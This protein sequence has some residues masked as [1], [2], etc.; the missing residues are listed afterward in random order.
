MKTVRSTKKVRMVLTQGDCNK[1]TYLELTKIIA[2]VGCLKEG[3]RTT[4]G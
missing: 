2:R 3:K 4:F 1:E